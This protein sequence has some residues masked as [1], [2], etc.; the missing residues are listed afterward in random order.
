M[1]ETQ[2]VPVFNWRR[3]RK[4][5]VENFDTLFSLYEEAHKVSSQMSEI[6]KN[7]KELNEQQEKLACETKERVL[8][9][10]AV[11]I[12]TSRA[13]QKLEKES[14][15]S[16]LHKIFSYSEKK[17]LQ[18]KAVQEYREKL[19]RYESEKEEFLKKE[20]ARLDQAQKKLEEFKIEKEKLETELKQESLDLK[21]KWQKQLEIAKDFQERMGIPVKYDNKIEK[22]RKYREYIVNMRADSITEAE[23][24]YSQD[25]AYSRELKK[26]R[27]KVQDKAFYKELAQKYVDVM[28]QVEQ[29]KKS[30]ELSEAQSA[31]DDAHRQLMD[32]EKKAHNAALLEDYVWHKN[33][34][35][36][37]LTDRA[38]WLLLDW[39]I[40]EVYG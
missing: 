30:M 31:L 21:Y 4:D 16:F 37:N 39:E 15:R 34:R 24:I 29:V 14:S 25:E 23:K 5:I 36:P 10:P 22:L 8:P 7:L 13:L 20:K 11:S 32:S 28:M 40:Q 1:K 3:S 27:E 2:E 19:A 12:E 33:Q 18:K 9:P 26:V 35:D 38:V 6:E 17:E